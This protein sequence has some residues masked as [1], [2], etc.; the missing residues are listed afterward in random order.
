[1]IST[2]M[3][4]AF[5]IGVTVGIISFLVVLEIG[6]RDTIKKD[7]HRRFERKLD[8]LED[9]VY[10]LERLNRQIDFDLFKGAE[11]SF[12]NENE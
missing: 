8:E 6:Y 9:T 2:E 10:A 11:G 5:L 1:M 12:R 3:V 4:I 7:A